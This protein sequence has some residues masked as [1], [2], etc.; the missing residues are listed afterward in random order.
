MVTQTEF[1]QDVLA[2]LKPTAYLSR[3]YVDGNGRRLQLYLGYHDGAASGEIHSPKHCLP[4]SGWQMLDGR[5]LILPVGGHNLSLVEAT[6]QSGN[7]KECIFYWYQVRGESLSSEYALKLAE[8]K[9]SFLKNRRD[10]A[11]IRISV[12]FEGDLNKAESCG[13]TVYPRFLSVYCCRVC[14]NDAWISPSLRSM[15][16]SFNAK[17][18]EIFQ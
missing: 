14:P 1:D 16:V 11:F 12:P 10:A 18:R 8:I 5:K 9:D 13:N 2:I 4:G 3:T 6:Y 7:L 15:P 17:E